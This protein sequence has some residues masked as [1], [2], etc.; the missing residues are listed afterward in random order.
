MQELPPHIKE[1]K[2]PKGSRA[3]EQV[4]KYNSS[5]ILHFLNDLNFH[6]VTSNSSCN[7]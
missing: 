5:D 2:F 6:F 1:A 3:K 4:R 7:N